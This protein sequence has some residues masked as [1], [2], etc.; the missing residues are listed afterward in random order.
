MTQRL[1]LKVLHAHYRTLVDSPSTTAG[2][3]SST[4]NSSK[5][6]PPEMLT[7]CLI[8]NCR[9]LD[10]LFDLSLNDMLVQFCEYCAE[11]RQF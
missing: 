2:G 3:E 1:Q 10:I 4:P 11:V 6:E 8:Q 7:M 5:E 9:M